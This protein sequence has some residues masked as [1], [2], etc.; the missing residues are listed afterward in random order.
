MDSCFVFGVIGLAIYGLAVA[1]YWRDFVLYRETSWLAA[2]FGSA[3][4]ISIASALVIFGKLTGRMARSSIDKVLTTALVCLPLGLMAA[5]A[6]SY[7]HGSIQGGPIDT[8]AQARVRLEAILERQARLHPRTMRLLDPQRQIQNV[9]IQGPQMELDPP[10]ARYVQFDL[11]T[12]CGPIIRASG[13]FDGSDPD[14]V[15]LSTHENC[16]P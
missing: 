4:W 13:F 16:S 3:L 7:G 2:T 10:S 8:E 5:L 9:S 1:V 15:Y 12:G 14:Q 11:D 6:A